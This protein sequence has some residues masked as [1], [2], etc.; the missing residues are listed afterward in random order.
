MVE[1]VHLVAAHLNNKRVWLYTCDTRA[2]TF[3]WIDIARWPRLCCL[4]LKKE[5]FSKT[6]FLLLNNI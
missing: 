3:I 4:F 6:E 5:D 2:D 1:S